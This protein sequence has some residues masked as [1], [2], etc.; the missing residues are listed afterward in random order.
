MCIRDRLN[1]AA[2][3]KNITFDGLSFDISGTPV[4]ADR[5]T[6]ERNTSSNGVAD[7]RNALLLGKL[8]SQGT[9]SGGAANY[10]AAYAQLVSDNG[11]KTREIQVTRDAQKSLFDQS[12]AAREAMSGV[13]LDEEAANLIRYQQAYQASAKMLSIGTKLFDT[14]LSISG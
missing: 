10:Q 6:V 3:L 13:N 8:Q 1:G 4:A 11:N 2:T 9:V 14:L 5:F 7:G 12:S